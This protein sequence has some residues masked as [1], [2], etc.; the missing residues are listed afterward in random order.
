MRASPFLSEEAYLTHQD[1]WIYVNGF[2]MQLCKLRRAAEITFS[3]P[4]EQLS[5]RGNQLT[6]L[7]PSAS[8]PK[9]L[10]LGS[11]IRQLGLAVSRV[12]ARA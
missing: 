1:V 12:S 2:F 8:S 4:R 9:A 5:M 7:I 6:F 10:G 3:I 11:D